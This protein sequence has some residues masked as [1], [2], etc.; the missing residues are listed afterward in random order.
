LSH[1]IIII[2]HIDPLLLNFDSSVLDMSSSPNTPHEKV[3][4]LRKSV[5]AVPAASFPSAAN[6]AL[7]LSQTAVNAEI[8]SMINEAREHLTWI[9]MMSQHSDPDL[10]KAINGAITRGVDVNVYH[11]VNPYVAQPPAHPYPLN[12]VPMHGTKV[13]NFVSTMLGSY[14]NPMRSNVTHSRFL[15]NE[16]QCMFGGVD[17]NRICEADNYVQ[18][19]IKISLANPPKGLAKQDLEDVVK[20]L[21]L[22][23][24]RDYS[25]P[26]DGALIG[27]SA[28]DSSALDRIISMIRGA[29]HSIFIEN[30]YFQ[31]TE[32]LSAIA[33]RQSELPNIK[34]TLVGNH[35]FAINP[36]HPGKDGYLSPVIGFALSNETMGGLKFLKKLG[37]LFQFRT[38]RN[39]YTHNKIFIFDGTQLVVGTFNLHQRSLIAGRD[40]EIG[41]VVEGETIVAKY[42]NDVMEDTV[43]TMSTK[44]TG[45]GSGNPAGIL[46]C[47]CGL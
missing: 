10:I 19:A 1:E 9:S 20:H 42:M 6:T 7:V 2:A 15:M 40:F 11:N 28:V 25:F 44:A 17:F 39:K 24:L 21:R 13:F 31:H 46:C 43:I 45:G 47:S 8:L 16:T 41:V 38:Y 14:V 18:H 36:Y 23:H 3:L 12:I 22:N 33:A 26:T 30:Q 37:C 32:V 34:V 5:K 27:T 29:E 4:T 35:D